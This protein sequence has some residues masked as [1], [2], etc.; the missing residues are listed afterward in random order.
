[1]PTARTKLAFLS[2]VVW[3]LEPL[4]FLYARLE[5][6]HRRSAELAADRVAADAYGGDSLARGLRALEDLDA[7]GPLF[8]DFFGWLVRA[9][10][11]I[12]DAYG[13]IR[14]LCSEPA[15]PSAPRKFDPLD[16]HPPT[17]E[18]IRAVAGIGQGNSDPRPATA[19]LP[20]ATAVRRQLSEALVA[21]IQRSPFAKR[22]RI[23]PPREVPR[24]GDA[25]AVHAFRLQYRAQRTFPMDRAAAAALAEEGLRAARDLAGEEDELVVLALATAARC[26]DPALSQERIM[27]A[28]HILRRR[29][30]YD[31]DRDVA[32]SRLALELQRTA[33]SSARGAVRTAAQA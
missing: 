23:A 5:A 16:S 33:P 9:G 8:A 30:D 19:L 14:A 7:R 27:K 1:M 17:E 15:P 21:D 4:E 24:G 12:E 2:P 18:R 28:R 32:L 26:A 10:G 11:R 31:T 13:C 3:Y 20:D 29:R 22:I 6:A 25:A